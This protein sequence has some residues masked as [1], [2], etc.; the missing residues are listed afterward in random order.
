MKAHYIV[1]VTGVLLSGCAELPTNPSETAAS[2]LAA[3]DRRAYQRH[4]CRHVH[5]KSLF[6]LSDAVLADT[7]RFQVGKT[8]YGIRLSLDKPFLGCKEARVYLDEMDL[9]SRTSARSKA[10]Q[11]RSVR[12]ERTLPDDAGSESLLREAKSIV[13]E[14]SKWLSVEA[15]DVELSD[16]GPQEKGLKRIRSLGG[17]TCVCFNLAEGQDIDVRL[18]EGLYVMRDGVPRL[19]DGPSIKIDITY[20]SELGIRALAMSIRRMEDEKRHGEKTKVDKEI[21]IGPDCSDKLAKA[22]HDAIIKDNARAAEREGRRRELDQLRQ[23]LR[24]QREA[25]DAVTS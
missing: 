8:P 20:N 11:L 13:A 2:S 22:L 7:N 21:D 23:E 6:G 3:Q 19:I 5:L 17:H 10:H 1:I 15:P 25:L 9:P 18:F 12:L 14:I 16:V 24:T 4:D